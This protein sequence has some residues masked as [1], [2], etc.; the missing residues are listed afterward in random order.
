M[1]ISPGSLFLSDKWLSPSALKATS[2][3]M[4]YM[5]TFAE[6]QDR[7]NFY[8]IV[9]DNDSHVRKNIAS[10]L[11]SPIVNR[12]NR[13][14]VEVIRPYTIPKYL[15]TTNMM[16]PLS[17]KNSKAIVLRHCYIKPEFMKNLWETTAS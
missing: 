4:D 3:L 13:L 11:G 1:S 14:D 12:Y 10:K 16:G 2:D 17:G 7:F 5:I 8:H 6:S 9:R 15:T